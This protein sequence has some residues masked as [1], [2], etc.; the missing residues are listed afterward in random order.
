MDRKEKKNLQR[1]MSVQE[2]NELEKTTP[3]EGRDPAGRNIL[4]SFAR[5]DLGSEKNA[6]FMTKKSAK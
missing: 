4:R 3:K 5:P 6:S 2:E 1:E